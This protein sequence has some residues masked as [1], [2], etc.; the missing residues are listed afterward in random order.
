GY[1]TNLLA[2]AMP[3]AMQRKKVFIGLLGNAVNSAFNYPN[4]FSMMPA[5][6]D[7]SPSFT[8]GFFDVAVRQSPK[9]KTVAIVAADA[10]VCLN[11]SEGAR[12]HVKAAGLT[13]PRHRLLLSARLGRH[14]ASGQRG[15]LP[16]ENDRRC[17]G[18][19]AE[20]GDQGSTRSAAQ[21]LDQFRQLAA[22]SED[23][24]RR[25]GRLDEEVPSARG[26]RRR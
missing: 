8:K 15:R 10:E 19:P 20:H 22:G 11:A 5:G 25:R 23:A 12:E 21:R 17:H 18:R 6:P 2:P 14:G 1:G 3:I 13:V 4:Y 16:A 26:G 24:V 9:P 7:P